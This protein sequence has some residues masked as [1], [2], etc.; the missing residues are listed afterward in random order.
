MNTP[1]FSN[2]AEKLRFIKL[3]QNAAIGFKDSTVFDLPQGTILI[4]NFYYPVDFRKPDG[5]RRIIE[6]RLLVHQ[7]SGWEAWPYIWND[8][9]TEAEYD[10]AGDTKNVSYVD[11]KGKKKMVSYAIPNKNQCKGCHVSKDKLLPIGL[12][13]RQLNGSILVD[14][15]ALNQLQFWQDKKMFKETKLPDVIPTMPIWTDKTQ[16]L[17]LRARAYLDANCGHCHSRSGPASTSALFLDYFEKDPLHLGVRSTPPR[18]TCRR[19]W[20]R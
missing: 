12:T 9:Q 17:E 5:P 13:A 8:A 6:T 15:T 11:V 7:P 20:R 3:P 16:P 19:R 4:K 10:P 18:P 14:K 2:Y 1:L